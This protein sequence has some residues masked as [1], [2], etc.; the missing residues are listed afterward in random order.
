MQN[1]FNALLFGSCLAVGTFSP[2]VL[3]ASSKVKESKPNIL[4][5]LAD[6]LGLGDLSCQYAKDIRTPNIDRIFNTGLRLTNCHANSTVSSPSRAGLLT[7]RFPAMVGVPGV[8]RTNAYQCWGYLQPG[9]IILPQVLRDNDYNTALIGKWHLGWIWSQGK[10]GEKVDFSA[11]VSNG[12]SVLGFE[13]Y[14]CIA[15]SL[16]MPPYV[17]VENDRIMAVPDHMMKKEKGLRLIR[18]G[19]AAPDFIPE[20]CLDRFVGR[21][22]DYIMSMKDEKDPFFLYFPLT[23]PHTPILPSDE[24]IGKSGLSPYGDFVMMVDDAV[25]K[26][27]DALRQSG[28]LGNT[29]VIFASDNGCAPG[30]DMAYMESEG[31]FP[32]YVFRGAK[33]DLFEGGHR[34]PLIVSWGSRYA[35][36]RVEDCLVS[37]TDLYAT[38]AEITGYQMKENEGEDSFSLLPVLEGNNRY[39]RKDMVQHSADGSLAL[40][41]GRWKL[42]FTGSS[43]GWSYPSLPKDSTAVAALPAFQL[44]NIEKDKSESLNLVSRYPFR[45]RRMAAIMRKYIKKGRSTDGIPQK[46]DLCSPWPQT[47]SFMKKR[48]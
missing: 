25:G 6:D 8:I 41:R 11:P 34:I 28:K 7:G 9:V 19:P 5:I 3:S 42:L 23:A 2:N 35:G 43:G 39:S 21:A 12:P 44:Y 47:S 4:L 45:V 14:Y 27:I 1:R 46:N 16:D 37:L 10:N 31:H 15:A 22:S 29:I 48:F 13:Y 32:S 40:R 24:F 26:I 20:E 17:Y 33:S 18:R 36:G 38:F 30:S